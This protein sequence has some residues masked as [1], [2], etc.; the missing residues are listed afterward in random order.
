MRRPM[1]S[2]RQPYPRLADRIFGAGRPLLGLMLPKGP[3]RLL[4]VGLGDLL[5]GSVDDDAPPDLL[6]SQAG[7]RARAE[8]ASDSIRMRF[9]TGAIVK[10][11]SLN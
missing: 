8:R 10:G 7:A 9:G 2:S 6:D 4:G 5:T 3:F 11:R 1:S